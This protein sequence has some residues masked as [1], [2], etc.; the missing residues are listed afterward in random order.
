MRLPRVEVLY[1][2]SVIFT[3]T[4]AFTNMLSFMLFNLLITKAK[5]IDSQ[6]SEHSQLVTSAFYDTPEMNFR[7]YENY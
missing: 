5:V 7:Y 1:Q 6:H 3:A 2:V 4:F